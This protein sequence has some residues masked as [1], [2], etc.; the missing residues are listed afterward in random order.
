MD[1]PGFL[2]LDGGRLE[3]SVTEYEKSDSLAAEAVFKSP[4]EARATLDVIEGIYDSQFMDE[5]RDGMRSAITLRCGVEQN[6]RWTAHYQALFWPDEPPFI[7]SIWSNVSGHNLGYVLFHDFLMRVGA[8]NC[9]Y[10]SPTTEKGE[11]LLRKAIADNLIRKEADPQKKWEHATYW[12]VMRDPVE[13]LRLK[14]ERLPEEYIEFLRVLEYPGYAPE[15][16]FQYDSQEG[17]S[18]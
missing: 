3:T 9:F 8:G 11:H 4:L 2:W 17:D 10:A 15:F 6:G 18:P 1:Y 7:M 12:R 14:L 5:R 13:K 16:L